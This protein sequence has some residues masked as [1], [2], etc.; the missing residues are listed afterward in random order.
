MKLVREADRDRYLSALF[1]PDAVRPQLLAL[2][3]FDAEIRRIPYLVSEPQLGEIRLQWWRDTIDA[4]FEGTVVDHPVAAQLAKAIA[5]GKLQSAS[6]HRLVD[7]HVRDLYADAM[8]SLND[9]EGYLG[10]TEGAVMVMAAQVLNGGT[11]QGLGD[12]AGLGS[13]ARGIV[14]LLL[15]KPQLPHGAAAFFP[16]EMETEMLLAHAAQRLQEARPS[17]QQL[18]KHVLPAFL[19]LT[20]VAA[21]L[22]KLKEKGPAKD[23]SA[24]RAQWLIWLGRF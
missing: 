1:A 20:T 10:E 24:L 13:V 17:L 11:V 22:A 6:L 8:P 21:R 19:P 5:T 3:A 16:K 23:I 12:A 18:P 4:V 9:L 7:A 14:N 2:Y 15:A